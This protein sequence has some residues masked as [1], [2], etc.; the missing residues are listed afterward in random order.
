M[1][2][3][4]ASGVIPVAFLAALPLVQWCSL[5]S[6]PA[7]VRCLLVGEAPVAAPAASAPAC[8]NGCGAHEGAER[9]CP[10][11]QASRRAF[12]IGAAMGGPGMRPLAPVLIAPPGALPAERPTLDD[13]ARAP[14]RVAWE[15]EARPPSSAHVRR[16]P[17]RAP[18]A[19]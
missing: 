15:T 16:P 13:A 4:L 17:A 5:A 3:R 1:W 9:Q 19:S 7:A 11:Q 18:P 14:G 2:Q 6:D 10:L 12:C 8:A